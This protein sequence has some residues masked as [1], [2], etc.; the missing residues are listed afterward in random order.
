[1]Q[2]IDWLIIAAYFLASLAIGLAFSARAGRNLSEYFVSGRDVPWWLAGT[3]MVATTFAADTPLAVAGLVVQNGVAGNWLWWSFVM[4][5]MLTVFFY[6]RLWRRS[7]VLT[8]IEFTELRYG[9]RPAAILRGFRALYLGL[10]I[11]SIIMGWV[12][13]AM[14]KILGLTVGIDRWQAIVL[15]FTVTALYSVISGLWGVLVTD[16][17]QFVLAMVGCVALAVFALD[18]VGGIDG[19]KAGLTAQHGSAEQILA[20]TPPADS[21]WM[22][23]ATFLILVGVGWWASWYPGA[24]PGGGGYVAQRMFSARSEKDS[25]YATLWFTIA[26]YAL[27][28]WPWILVALAAMVLYPKLDDPETGYIRVMIDVLPAGWRGLMLAAFAAAYMSTIATHLNWG[29]SYLVNDFYRRFVRPEADERHY[30]LVSRL[31][32]VVV[33]LLAALATSQLDSIRGAWQLLL[34]IGA[35]TGPV[36]LLR[37]YWW[38]INAW[39]EIAAQ[40]AALGSFVLTSTVLKLNPDQPDQF[41]LSLV[42]SV[43][44]TTSAWLAVTFLTPPESAPVLER[45]YRTVRPEGTLWAPVAARLGLRPGAGA[46]PLTALHWLAGV[47]LVYGA[48]FGIGKLLFK[49]WLAGGLF[50][51]AAAVAGFVLVRTFQGFAVETPPLREPVGE[52]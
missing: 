9:G 8:D 45:F 49:E 30:V 10:P 29:T 42:I 38:R 13:L 36:Y 50:L 28:P 25:L 12:T 22:P 34:A 4:G 14:A 33:M 52:E 40:V 15:C 46:L 7:G 21:P 3:S 17:F 27:R 41:A 2:A 16:A 35:G 11:N 37:W 48:L 24:E 5:G 31:A 23:L 43:A 47:L 19:L 51:F 6:A 1:L 32:T 44:I 39:S 18:A 20:F 26:H